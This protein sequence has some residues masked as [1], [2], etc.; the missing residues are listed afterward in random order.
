MLTRL[1]AIDGVQSSSALLANDGNRIVQI[2]IRPGAN[3]SSVIE[4]VQTVLHAEVPNG[5]PVRLGKSVAL[6]Q[7]Q[8]WLTIGQLNALAALDE[9]P[10]RPFHM[11]YWLLALTVLIALAA[12][13]F[14]LLRH[15]RKGCE[16]RRAT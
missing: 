8:D 12:F 16:Q 11:G 15:H 13:G 1:N 9:S 14:W 10:S 3:A 6:G 5:S 2:T 7:K 4:K